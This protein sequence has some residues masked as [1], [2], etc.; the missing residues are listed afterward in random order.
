MIRHT[1]SAPMQYGMRCTVVCGQTCAHAAI[2]E[3]FQSP[4]QSYK[5]VTPGMLDTV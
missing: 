5:L 3:D 1:D 4:A 2:K